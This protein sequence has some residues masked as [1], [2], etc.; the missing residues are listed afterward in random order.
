MTNY[1]AKNESF[2]SLQWSKLHSNRWRQFFLIPLER[3]S[4][5]RRKLGVFSVAQL[6]SKSNSTF[7]RLKKEI[8]LLEKLSSS[9]QMHRLQYSVN[10]SVINLSAYFAEY[11]NVERFRQQV[12]STSTIIPIRVQKC[13]KI[14]KNFNTIPLIPNPLF[15]SKHLRGRV[16]S[17]KI[18]QSTMFVIFTDETKIALDRRC[19]GLPKEG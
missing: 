12:T 7:Q 1:S 8:R 10:V 3:V 13:N 14:R 5:R 18:G 17:T 4:R 9:I 16:W 15:M 11:L 2:S 19:L 6:F